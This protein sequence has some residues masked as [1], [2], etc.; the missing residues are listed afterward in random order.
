MAIGLENDGVAL[1]GLED[2]TATGEAQ[3]AVKLAGI[4]EAEDA[5][6]LFAEEIS[7]FGEESE[8]GVAEEEGFEVRESGGMG[9][10]GSGAGRFGFF[11]FLAELFGDFGDQK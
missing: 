10:N 5:F 4:V 9:L 7:G 6:G 1:D 2:F 11:A 8:G 3:L